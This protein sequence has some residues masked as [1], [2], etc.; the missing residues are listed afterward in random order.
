MRKGAD[1]FIT[2]DVSYHKAHDMMQMGLRAL[3]VGHSAEKHFK[4]AMK[5]WLEDRF[6]GLE[7]S[8][9]EGSQDPFKHI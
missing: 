3:D 2:G 4:T 1:L 6:D 5:T 8:V 9:Y 7:A